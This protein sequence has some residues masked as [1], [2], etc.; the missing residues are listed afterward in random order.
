MMSRSNGTELEKGE[1]SGSDKQTSHLAASPE[2]VV[3][4]VLSLTTQHNLLEI[5][6][7]LCVRFFRR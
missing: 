3:D 5:R 6:P 7:S 2:K 1:S 4:V